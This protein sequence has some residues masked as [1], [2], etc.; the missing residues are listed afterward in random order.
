MLPTE[1]DWILDLL[2]FQWPNV[3][4][5]KMREAAEAWSHFADA[6]RQAA[7]DGATAANTVRGANSGEAVEGFNNHWNKFA[8]DAGFL[9]DA[10]DAAEAIAI[11]LQVVATIVMVMK[12]AVIVQLIALAIELAMA[13]AAAPVTLGAS[14]AGAAAATATTRTIVRKIFDE[15]KTKIVEAVK[16]A[17]AKEL[18]KKWK[19]MLKDLGMD[20][21]KDAAKKLGGNLASQGIKNYFGAQDGFDVKDAA[22]AAAN[23]LVEKAKDVGKVGTGAYHM[24]EGVGEMAEGDFAKGGKDFLKGQQE[25]AD[26]AKSVY[27][28][29]YK[30][31]GET[32]AEGDGTDSGSSSDG[33]SGSGGSSGSSSEGGSGS[34]GSSGA[35]SDGGSGGSSSSGGG[36]DGSAAAPAGGTRSRLA[37]GIPDTEAADQ[38]GESDGEAARVRNAFG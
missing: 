16:E 26:G 20:L 22:K 14:E 34:G 18:R 10:A 29:A 19:D 8:G 23:P 38:D 31:K 7:S 24:A 15:A 6:C 13:Q 33:D 4:E 11:V 17:L 28:I 3:D 5:D 2:G 25:T 36:S 27:D 35:S 32:P 12:I 21:A 37:D 30:K 1:V 9:D